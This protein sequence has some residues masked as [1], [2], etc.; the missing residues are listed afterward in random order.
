MIQKLTLFVMGM[1]RTPVMVEIKI[2]AHKLTTNIVDGGSEV[3]V[4]SKET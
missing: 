1:G 3:N 4:L 2:M